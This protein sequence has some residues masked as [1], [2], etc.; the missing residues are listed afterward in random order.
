MEILNRLGIRKV[1][2]FDYLYKEFSEPVYAQLRSSDY[3]TRLD[4]KVWDSPD[5]YA[6]PAEY[7]SSFAKFSQVTDLLMAAAYW[8]P[9]A[10]RLF[11]PD[12]MRQPDF[13]INTIADITCDIDGSVPCTKR[14]STILDPVY[15]YNPETELLEPAFSRPTNITIMAVDNLPCEL[16]RNASRDFGRQLID[17]VFPHLF[18][19]DAP[20]IIRRATIARHGQL[21]PRYE[22]LQEYA[23]G[24]VAVH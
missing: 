24:K 21:M 10:P 20:G 9:A 17:A 5:F 16:P 4:G 18:R 7:E 12:E 15:D 23:A 22:Y 8:N 19:N 3:N 11:S 1:S 13:K 14:A 6:H 2:V